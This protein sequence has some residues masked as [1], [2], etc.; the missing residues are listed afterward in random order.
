MVQSP[1]LSWLQR[2]SLVWSGLDAWCGKRWNAAP[3]QRA[4]MIRLNSY[5]IFKL[6]GLPEMGA[7]ARFR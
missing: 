7:L 6:L 1:S 2:G 3:V 4:A 5:L